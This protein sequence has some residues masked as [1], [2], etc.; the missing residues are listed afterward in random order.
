MTLNS[1]KVLLLSILSILTPL[2]SMPPTASAEPFFE[3]LEDRTA[4]SDLKRLAEAENQYWNDHGAYTRSFDD[5][6]PTPF[7][8]TK[9]TYLEIEQADETKLRA[10]SMPRASTTARVFVLEAIEGRRHI[11]EMDEREVQ[12]YVL[13]ALSTL[14]QNKRLKLSLSMLFTLA[15]AGLCAYGVVMHRRGKQGQWMAS[16]PY[17]LSLLTL[18]VTLILSTYVDEHTYI[19]PL[20]FW[21][22]I[23]GAISALL[24]IGLGLTSLWKLVTQDE[25]FQLRRLALIGVLFSLLGIVSP[26]YTY[27]PHLPVIGEITTRSSA[28]RILPP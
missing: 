2:V 11:D 10:I 24:S 22:A 16:A 17:F 12:D 7:E 18:Y 20:I 13:G 14:R 25:G 15:V 19:R 28:H 5:L 27:Y 6:G 23:A 3:T 21:I 9:G 8:P 4:F 1:Q 26:F